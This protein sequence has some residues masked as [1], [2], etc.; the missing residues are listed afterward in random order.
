MVFISIKGLEVFKK[1]TGIKRSTIKELKIYMEVW[2]A[3]VAAC[4]LSQQWFSNLFRKRRETITKKNKKGN[5]KS[6]IET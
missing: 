5:S 6:K 3:L 1:P 4:A 2:Y